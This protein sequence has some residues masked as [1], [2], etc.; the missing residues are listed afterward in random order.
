M[1]VLKTNTERLT[2]NTIFLTIYIIYLTILTGL[3]TIFAE[4]LT[5]LTK[6]LLV[7]I[8]LLKIFTKFHHIGLDS[9]DNLT[10]SQISQKDQRRMFLTSLKFTI[11]AFKSQDHTSFILTQFREF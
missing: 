11:I 2:I 6:L 5:I 3:L 1:K 9:S 4:I 10:Q 8:R 7:K